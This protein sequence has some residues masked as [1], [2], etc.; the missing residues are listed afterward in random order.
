VVRLKIQMEEN[1]GKRIHPLKTLYTEKLPEKINKGKKIKLKKKSVQRLKGQRGKGE[2]TSSINQ[3]KNSENRSEEKRAS[4]YEKKGEYRRVYSKLIIW[5][6]GKNTKKS[7]IAT[8]M[9]NTSERFRP[10][11]NLV[12][13]GGNY[14]E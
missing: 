7:E 5:H 4:R 13:K 11:P 3:E 2:S 1:G 10:I 6:E 8:R 12:Q 14:R 9:E